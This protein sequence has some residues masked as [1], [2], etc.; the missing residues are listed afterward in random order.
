MPTK[1]LKD[2]LAPCPHCACQGQELVSNDILSYRYTIKCPDCP[3]SAEYYSST[4]EQAIAHWNRRS[5]AAPIGDVAE[6]LS[7]LRD[8]SD[9][10]RN[11]TAT[12]IADLLDR[13]ASMLLSLSAQVEQRQAKI[14]RLMLEYCPTEITQDQFTEWSKRQKRASPEIEKI[15]N[16]HMSELIEPTTTAPV[17]ECDEQ[18][19][20]SHNMSMGYDKEELRTMLTGARWAWQH[21]SA[22]RVPECDTC[23]GKGTVDETLG[24]ESFSN[25]FA[26]CPDCDGTGKRRPPAPGNPGALPYDALFDLMSQEHGLSLTNSEMDAIIG[27]CNRAAAKDSGGVAGWIYEDTLPDSYPYETMFQYSAIIEGVRMFPVYFPTLHE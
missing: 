13:A 12:D 27:V 17:M 9:L 10:C 26:E 1:E 6:L 14:D 25:P 16:E 15:I 11:E 3:A 20:L 19:A 22:G 8:E 21:L 2:C 7:D 24:G 4:K 18:F 5:H 23:Q